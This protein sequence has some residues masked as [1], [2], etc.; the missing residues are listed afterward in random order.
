VALGLFPLRRRKIRAGTRRLILLCCLAGLAG[1]LVDI[2]HIPKV[3]LN[4]AIHTPWPALS[5]TYG[6]PLHYPVLLISSI[7]LA[8]IGGYFSF[9]V[10]AM[11]YYSMNTRIAVIKKRV[12][13]H[14]LVID[15]NP[16]GKKSI[17]KYRF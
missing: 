10:L 17:E 1:G 8:C 6:R 9:L 2:D 7:G 13:G 12:S 14:Q 4:L 15:K 5:S 11:M 3:V 16:D